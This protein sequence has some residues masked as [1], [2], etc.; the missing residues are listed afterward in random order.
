[1][2]V[3][4]NLTVTCPFFICPNGC[5]KTASLKCL[6]VVLGMYNF[7]HIVSRVRKCQEFLFLLGSS[8]LKNEQHLDMH[9]RI[10]VAK[11]GIFKST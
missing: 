10:W 6:Y 1:M 7:D 5:A 11:K 8:K 9:G 3:L 2:G 4:A